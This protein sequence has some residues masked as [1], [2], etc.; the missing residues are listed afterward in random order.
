MVLQ[1]LYRTK[2]GSIMHDFFYLL[3]S[4]FAIQGILYAKDYFI[5][6]LL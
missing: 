6:F 2:L 4:L 5:N 3:D 1:I